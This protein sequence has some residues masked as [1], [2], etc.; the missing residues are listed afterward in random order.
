L[1]TAFGSPAFAQN[2]C[3]AFRA[4]TQAQFPS[5]VEVNVPLNIWGGDVYASLGAPGAKKQA[6]ALIGVFSGQDADD[7][8]TD[9]RTRKFGGMGTRGSYTFVLQ[10]PSQPAFSGQF[11]LALG[12]A[13]WN[14]GPGQSVGDYQAIGQVTLGTGVFANAT[15]SLTIHGAFFFTDVPNP[16]Y[17]PAKYDVNNPATYPTFPLGRWIPEVTGTICGVK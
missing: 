15:G 7:Y 6:Q 8:V 14:M 2:G 17:D 4:I 5:T 1:V 11:T 9:S 12:R 13:V 16:E 10:D 3:V